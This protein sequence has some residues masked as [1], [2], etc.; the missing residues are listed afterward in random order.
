MPPIPPPTL[1]DPGYDKLVGLLGCLTTAIGGLDQ[2][3]CRLTIEPGSV[4]FDIC[5]VSGDGLNNGQ[6]WVRE[7]NRY[8]SDVFPVQS[9]QANPC[10]G[11]T[12]M[13]IELGIVRCALKPDD[14]GTPPDPDAVTAQAQS[15]GL[16]GAALKWAMCCAFGGSSPAVP[17]TAVVLGPLT[18]VGP[19]GGCV[20]RLLTAVISL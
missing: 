20:G 16:D 5:D 14:N 4:A 6:A 18:P 1:T 3:V 2:G 19:Q 10:G 13:A 17:G 15:L 9:Q 8:P 12:A 11:M 7:T